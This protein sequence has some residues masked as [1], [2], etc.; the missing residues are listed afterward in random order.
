[1]TRRS[2]LV[3][4]ILLLLILMP[5]FHHRHSGSQSSVT[6]PATCNLSGGR[7]PAADRR[8]SPG[9]IT[10]ASASEICVVGYA[11]E[12]RNVS[13][14]TKARV[15]L[16]YGITHRGLYGHQGGYEID[17]IVPLELGGSNE[18]TNLYPEPYPAYVSK[19]RMENFMHDMVCDGS[20]S[21]DRAQKFFMRKYVK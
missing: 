15:Y 5:R 6:L 20:L 1:M 8:C 21:L 10:T 18:I 3:L 12:H 7:N 11:R 13:Q 14:E 19:D 9:R 16:L 17:H 4:I 2:L